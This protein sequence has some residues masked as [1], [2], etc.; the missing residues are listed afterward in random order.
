MAY[1]AELDSNNVV[2]RVLEADQA[3]IDANGGD[4]SGTAATYFQGIVGL[5]TNGVKYVQ[6][7]IDGS[8]R[9]NYAS[10]GFT[11]D[12]SKDAFIPAKKYASWVL[13]NTTCRYEAPTAKPE[14][15]YVWNESTESWDELT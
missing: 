4:E 6:T 3:D 13:N 11:Y 9:K 15:N 1:F 2:L 12:A 8:F 5:S 10:K 7:S 14:G